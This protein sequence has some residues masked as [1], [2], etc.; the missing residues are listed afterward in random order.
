MRSHSLRSVTT[1]IAEIAE[2]AEAVACG[3]CA[4][5]PV[6]RVSNNPVRPRQNR[7]RNDRRTVASDREEIADHG[8]RCRIASGARAG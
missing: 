7:R 6:R 1:I 2:T 3:V 4:F 8:N 5:C